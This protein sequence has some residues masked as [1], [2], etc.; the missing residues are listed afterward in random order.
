MESFYFNEIEFEDE[1]DTNFQ[2]CDSAPLFDFMLTQVSLADLDSIPKPILIPI[3]IEF[4]HEPPI[5]DTHIYCWEMNVNLNYM[6][7]TNP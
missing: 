3:P 4:E 5:L 7:W 2:F 6:I 1:C